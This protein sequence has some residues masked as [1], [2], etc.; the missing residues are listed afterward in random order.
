MSLSQI[1][2]PVCRRDTNILFIPN[3]EDWLP[4]LIN[5]AI[6]KSYFLTDSMML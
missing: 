1:A 3:N 2:N 4:Y 6:E 5:V